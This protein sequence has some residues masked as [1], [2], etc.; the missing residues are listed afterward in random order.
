MNELTDFN[1]RTNFLPYTYFR[2]IGVPNFVGAGQTTALNQTLVF[3]ARIACA[4]ER[5][6]LDHREYPQSLAILVPQYLDQIPHDTIGGQVPVYRRS[7]NGGFELS[8]AGWEA[9][10]RWNWPL[11]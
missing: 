9:K 3:Q 4:L 5:F 10:K 11:E 1:Q 7:E 8:S 2:T 6:R